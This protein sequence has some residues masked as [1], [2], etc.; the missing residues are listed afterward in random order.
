MTQEKFS[1]TQKDFY[2]VSYPRSGSTWLRAMLCEILYG[3]SG[4]S[5]EDLDYYSPNIYLRNKIEEVI[6]ADFH[7]VKT[8]AQ[9]INP[10]HKSF[11]YRKV[12]YLVRDPRDVVLSHYRYQSFLRDYPGSLDDFIADWLSGRVFPSTWNDHVESWIFFS[13]NRRVD[14]YRLC[15]I[16]YEDMLVSPE[17]ELQKIAEFMQLEKSDAD[18]SLAVE[19]C[20]LDAMRRKEKR[21]KRAIETKEGFDFIGSATSGSW[22]SSL[23]N[24]QADLI[25]KAN[26]KLMKKLGY[27]NELS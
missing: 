7:V 12:I 18:L 6:P 5:L 26:G 2:L 16:R 23:S 13:Q 4:E 17:R 15:L 8:H 14:D 11:P 25:L 24:A 21:G 3:R 19:K 27:L 10:W 9:C 1:P 22:K 20:R